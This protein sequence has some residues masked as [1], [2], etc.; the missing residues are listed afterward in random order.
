[1]S[2]DVNTRIL[3]PALMGAVLSL[4]AHADGFK[5]E[6]DR[7]SYGIGVDVATN[8]KRLEIDANVEQLIK[9]IRDVYAGNKLAITD[10]DL[11]ATMSKFQ[12]DLMNRQAAKTKLLA[13]GNKRL[14]EEF[15]AEN[16]TREGVV[17]L[18]S[19]LQYKILKAGEGPKPTDKDTVECN[20]RGTLIDGKEFDSSARAG[21]PAMFNLETV[22]PGWREALKLMPVGS[23]WQIFIPSD[24]AYG[25]RGAGRDIGPNAALIFELELL[26]IVSNPDSAG[27]AS[28]P[29]EPAAKP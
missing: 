1:M 10:A 11:Q 6:K 15:L 2:N 13:D 5:T 3:L 18:A 28:K 9:G 25:P 20:Y 19:G 23:R 7:Y 22:I 17:T 4:S 14:G 24:L 27:T 29:S 21:K 12:N 8:F 16:R 26:R